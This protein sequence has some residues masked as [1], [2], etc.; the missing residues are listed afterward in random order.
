[1]K[2]KRRMIK[3][4]AAWTVVYVI[5]IIVAAAP[6]IIAAV[7]LLPHIQM[8]RG[9]VAFGGEWIL[10]ALIFVLAFFYIDRKFMDWIYREEEERFKQDHKYTR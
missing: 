8:Q 5:E 2:R 10:L 6:T 1:M 7:L 4:Y 9:G 3:Y